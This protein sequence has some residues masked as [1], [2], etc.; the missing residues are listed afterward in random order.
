MLRLVA[1]R[2]QALLL[3]VLVAA[4][5][6][7][8]AWGVPIS[9]RAYTLMTND[10]CAPGDYVRWRGGPTTWVL[11]R[12]GA[13]GLEL[14]EVEAALEEA[15]EIWSAPCCSGFTSRYEGITHLRSLAPGEQN[16]IDFRQRDWPPEFGR[17]V[18]GVTNRGRTGRCQIP[19]ATMFFN[20]VDYRF[21]LTDEDLAENEVD[22]RYVAAHE[23]GHWLGLDH[24]D[25]ADSLMKPTWDRSTLYSGLRDD[26][27]DAV[28]ALYPG[29]CDPCERSEDCPRGSVCRDA[30]C[31]ATE[32]RI[33]SDCPVG[34]ICA[35]GG[36]CVPGCRSHLECEGNTRCLGGSCV[37]LPE[38]C[39][40]HV[41]CGE[42]E[43]CV[44][45]YCRE[46]PVS[47]PVC[48]RCVFDTDCGLYG[49]CVSLG[50]TGRRVCSIP[51]QNDRDC[52]GSSRCEFS[53]GASSG[54]CFLGTEEICQPGSR[55]EVR[56]TGPELGCSLLGQECTNGA[57]GCGERADTCIDGADGPKCSC[58]CRSDAECGPGGRCLLDPSTGLD[59][60][61]PE[62]LLA[63]CAGT[64]CVPGERCV[65]GSCAEDP[66]AWVSC[67]EGETCEEGKCVEPA[68]EPP[69]KKKKGK[70]GSCA[71]AGGSGELWLGGAGAVVFAS[72]RR[73]RAVRG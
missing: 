70:A 3:G 13:I 6:V 54:Y 69:A 53:P 25:V 34:T 20:E 57:F 30:A 26:D 46:L 40:H 66:C 61:Y 50:R 5:W 28:C 56:E 44:G 32:C 51:C 31:V 10:N 59:S 16:V 23:V 39:E 64:F 65:E 47:C 12:D 37:E 41:E 68:P 27:V 2:C 18:L 1:V 71:A 21:V 4:G 52:L 29:S 7:A 11:N 43:S 15:F 58:T 55:C 49:S 67:A 35:P 72:L 17:S 8:A 19:R 63:E 38:R 62:E 45:G 33:L 9:A 36:L 14:R 48:E 24:S 73:R 42:G 60:C 22:L